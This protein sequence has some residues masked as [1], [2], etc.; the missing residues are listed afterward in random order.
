MFIPTRIQ[1]KFASDTIHD[2]TVGNTD[3]QTP[4]FLDKLDMKV[5]LDYES[6]NHFHCLMRVQVLSTLPTVCSLLHC[7]KLPLEIISFACTYQLFKIEY[8]QLTNYL[9]QFYW[10]NL[11]PVWLLLLL[12]LILGSSSD[13][14]VTQLQTEHTN[15]WLCNRIFKES[16]WKEQSTMFL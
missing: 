11:L 12:M 16:M 14:A 15:K 5:K 10:R 2:E 1:K 3:F 7:L 4:K 8:L 9:F 13:H 6:K